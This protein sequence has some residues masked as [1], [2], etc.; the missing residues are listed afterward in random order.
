MGI[1]LSHWLALPLHRVMA[2]C[3]ARARVMASVLFCPFSPA[4]VLFVSS[5]IRLCP[6]A[7][8]PNGSCP[9]PHV[10][11]LSLCPFAVSLRPIGVL[12]FSIKHW[13]NFAAPFFSIL[14]KMWK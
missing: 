8:F 3:R 14:V 6:P 4:D 2:R 10:L 1:R 12:L 5:N 9:C 11:E 7:S 13:P